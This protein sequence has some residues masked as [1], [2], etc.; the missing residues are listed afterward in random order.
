MKFL[1][2]TLWAAVGVVVALLAAALL[3]RPPEVTRSLRPAHGDRG[4]FIHVEV[5]DLDRYRRRLVEGGT[6]RDAAALS[7]T[8]EA[9]GIQNYPWLFVIDHEGRVFDK[10]FGP[11]VARRLLASAGLALAL[12]LT[13][14]TL[15]D[16]HAFLVRSSPQAGERLTQ[17]PS[18]LTLEFSDVVVLGSQEVTVRTANGT[19][20]DAGRSTLSG[21]GTALRAELAPG[22]RGVYIVSWRVLAQDGA[23]TMGEFAFGVGTT[24]GL[25]GGAATASAPIAWPEVAAGWLLFVG[26]TLALGGLGSEA[27]VWRAVAREQAIEVPRGPVAV[28]VVIGLAGAAWRVWLASGAL[29]PGAAAPTG[30][31]ETWVERLATRPAL[32]SAA[33]VVLLLYAL[34]LLPLRWWRAWALLP[35]GGAVVLIALRGHSGTSESWWWAAPANAVHLGAAALWGGALLHLVLALRGFDREERW[36]V[37]G[38]AARR[39]ARLALG[40]VLLALVAGAVTV[41]AEFSRPSE[42]IET[43]Y[44][45]TLI[46]KLVLVTAALALALLARRRALPANPGIRWPLLSRL[47]RIESAA[48]LG[49]VTAAAVLVTVSSPR[50]APAVEDL[51]G[52]APLSGPVLRLASL[53]GQLSVYVAAAEGQLE[54]QVVTPSAERARGAH[55]DLDGEGPGGEALRLHPRRCGRGC[56][57]MRFPWAEGVTRLAVR[58]AAPGWAGGTA[59]FEVP[60]PPAP[61]EPELLERVITTMRAEPRV[62]LVEQ[63]SSGPAALGPRNTAH[64][65]GAELMALEPYAASGANDVRRLPSRSGL[66]NLVLYLP[67]S[68]IWGRLWV[69]EASRIQ[70]AV[71][72]SPGHLIERA[73]FYED[74]RGKQRRAES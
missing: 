54:V 1:G 57:T 31:A 5:Y 59:R 72:V 58:T 49:A 37:V 39:Y 48:L 73:L 67:G 9:W 46:A 60:W 52:A 24:A 18:A 4:E 35:L 71:L 55:V 12:V 38:A 27:F 2:A 69:D 53:A 8:A 17:S 51:L 11:M 62:T 14:P 19:G 41:L 56:F 13:L 16:A 50:T 43:D 45:R 3:W 15:A 10:L 64:L 32:L 70:R 40:L 34:W 44:G 20:I 65:S 23:V 63:T 74:D 29:A 47:V 28:G 36:R 21:T 30:S 6:P 25:S 66:T 68:Y 26:L 22:L 7:A 42:L 33:A 61:D